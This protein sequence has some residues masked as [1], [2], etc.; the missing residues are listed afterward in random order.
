MRSLPHGHRSVRKT[1]D[2]DDITLTCKSNMHSA[3]HSVQS[4]IKKKQN[5]NEAEISD[6]EIVVLV[7]QRLI[8]NLQ[9]E[10]GS[11]LIFVCRLSRL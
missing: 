8:Y 2:A 10:G 4:Q 6:V 7:L 11:T 1:E 9:T 3:Y 5:S